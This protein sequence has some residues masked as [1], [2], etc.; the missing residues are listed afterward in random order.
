MQR[1][2]KL[3]GLDAR[4]DPILVSSR[5]WR[6]GS[7]AGRRHARRCVLA[8]SAQEKQEIDVLSPFDVL[9]ISMYHDGYVHLL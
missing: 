6:C 8:A 5:G 9:K 3:H 7:K 4:I 1:Q 2:A